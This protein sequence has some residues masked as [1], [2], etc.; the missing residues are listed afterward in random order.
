MFFFVIH[1]VEQPKGRVISTGTGLP[2][3]R[4]AIAFAPS[5]EWTEA[6]SAVWES[7]KRPA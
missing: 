1:F 6:G 4:A 2:S 3:R 7:S 5:V